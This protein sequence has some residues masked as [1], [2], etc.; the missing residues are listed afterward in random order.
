LLFALRP[1][2]EAETEARST[3]CKGGVWGRVDRERC[4]DFPPREDPP[5]PRD[6]AEFPIY[7]S[8]GR[9]AE[10]RFGFL[11]TGRH[12]PEGVLAAGISARTGRRRK[13]SSAQ[14]GM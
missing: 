2:P 7:L 1:S 6:R 8:P 3:Q 11:P 9:R 10:T 4:Q 13:H 12:R 14:A 5:A